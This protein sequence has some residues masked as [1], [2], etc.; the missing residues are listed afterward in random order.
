MGLAVD[1]RWEATT[2]IMYCRM[3]GSIFPI[4]YFLHPIFLNWGTVDPLLREI[5][6]NLGQMKQQHITTTC[7]CISIV[8]ADSIYIYFKSFIIL[9]K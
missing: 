8:N 7:V 6:L 5:G 4:K 3:A 2:I 9:T 1:S